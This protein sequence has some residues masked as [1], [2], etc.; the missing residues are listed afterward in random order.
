MAR[1]FPIALI[2]L[3]L[4][5]MA[6]GQM[7]GHIGG[8]RIGTNPGRFNS[9]G[10][11]YPLFFADYPSPVE[12]QPPAPVVIERKV[13]E[14]DRPTEPLMIEWNGERFV[15]YG[16]TQAAAEAPDYT[17]SMA[18]RPSNPATSHDIPAT[19]IFRDGHREQVSDY[20]ITRGGLYASADYLTGS[21]SRNIRLSSL[22]L[23]ATIKLNAK[24]G[25]NFSL[26]ASPNDVVTRP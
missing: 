17:E 26:P 2:G 19:L 7:R 8:L 20:V 3:A 21:P 24:D 13:I 11:G 22:D 9:R 6:A 1:I 12:V 25:V 4:A 15:R 16:T 10:Y 5:P 18:S 23:A 14:P